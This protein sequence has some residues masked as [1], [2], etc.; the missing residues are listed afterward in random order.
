MT[1]T[2]FDDDDDDDDDNDEQSDRH[3]NDNCYVHRQTVLALLRR[4]N[5]IRREAQK[6]QQNVSI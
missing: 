4:Y 3:A 6:Q 1:L 2:T 5:T